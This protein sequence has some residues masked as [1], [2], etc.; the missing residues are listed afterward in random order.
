MQQQQRSSG[1][2]A[3]SLVDRLEPACRRTREARV[4]QLM[5][6]GHSAML[7]D[8]AAVDPV[9]VSASCPLGRAAGDPQHLDEF[10]QQ[11]RQNAGTLAYRLPSCR[12]RSDLCCTTSACT[13]VVL[14]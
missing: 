2:V 6:A 13:S 3:V 8:L 11:C 7:C 5:T 14:K 1:S 9:P 10:V 12:V 4:G